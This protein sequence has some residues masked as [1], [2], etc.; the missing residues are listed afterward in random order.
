MIDVLPS[1]QEVCRGQ[2]YMSSLYLTDRNGGL[3]CSESIQYSQRF[4]NLTDL[5][6]LVWQGLLTLPNIPFLAHSETALLVPW[7]L[8][9]ATWLVLTN[10]E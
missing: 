10:E 5:I 9:R 8:G 3:S 4:S 7:H 1:H 6:L 2:K